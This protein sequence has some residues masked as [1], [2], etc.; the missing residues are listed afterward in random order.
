MAELME[1]NSEIDEDA[2]EGRYLTFRLGDE[3]FGIEI[4]YVMEIVGI[5]PITEMPEMPDYIKGIINLRGRIIPVVDVRIRFKKKCKD[6]NDRTCVV[7]I[8]YGGITIGLIVDS[9]S[10]V[11]AI[12]FEQISEKP[13]ISAKDSRGY[14]RNIG[15]LN[16]QVILL[17]DCEKLLNEN[18]LD[19]IPA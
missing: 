1:N 5:Q 18:D 3:I 7:V 4:R 11:M 15:R 2:M 13:E 10:D 6:Y 19:E 12:P 16:E 14:I 8:Q 9:V 17:I